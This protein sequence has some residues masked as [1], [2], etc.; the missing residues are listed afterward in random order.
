M[1]GARRAGFCPG[2]GAHPHG[3]GAGGDRPAARRRLAARA[4]QAARWQRKPNIILIVADDLG[5]NDL[6]FAGGGSGVAGGQVPTPN[7]DSIGEMNVITSG[8]NAEHGRQSSGLVQITT[9]S[10]TNQLR[11]CPT[12]SRPSIVSV[13]PCPASSALSPTDRQRKLSRHRRKSRAVS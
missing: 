8:Y 11:G 7:I 1:P 2:P 5:Y 6:T 13:G 12:A 9:K 3:A 4:S 10:G